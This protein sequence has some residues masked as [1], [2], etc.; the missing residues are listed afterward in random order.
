MICFWLYPTSPS[1]CLEEVLSIHCMAFPFFSY[2]NWIF[3][4]GPLSWTMRRFSLQHQIY[5][6]YACSH[7]FL[8]RLSVWRRWYSSDACVVYRIASVRMDLDIDVTVYVFTKGTFLARSLPS[9]VQERVNGSF[10]QKLPSYKS[11]K[12]IIL[13]YFFGFDLSLILLLPMQGMSM[14]VFI[15]SFL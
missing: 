5:C 8:P 10:N 13:I 15:K 1:F 4:K 11:V 2:W 7:G 14:V 3:L 12:H 9:S 6:W